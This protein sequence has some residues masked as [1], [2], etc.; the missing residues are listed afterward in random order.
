LNPNKPSKKKTITRL[1]KEG[2]S[3]QEIVQQT[4]TTQNYLNK[5]RTQQK[6]EPMKKGDTQKKISSIKTIQQPSVKSESQQADE[7]VQQE[8]GKDLFTMSIDDAEALYAAPAEVMQLL[9]K[10]RELPE[11]RIKTQGKRIYNFLLKHQI[12]IPYVEILLLMTGAAADY[13]SIIRDYMIEQKKQRMLELPKPPPAKVKE[14]TPAAETKPS[15]TGVASKLIDK[16]PGKPNININELAKKN[17]TAS[18]VMKEE[19]KIKDNA[20]P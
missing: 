15:D 13:G 10:T 4:G 2:R 19:K 20:S 3:D 12:N 5:V 17:V 14:V 8:K 18:P 1:I 6:K 16:I 9:L 7:P 11:E